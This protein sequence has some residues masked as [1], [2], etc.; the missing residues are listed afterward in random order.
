MSDSH[1]HHTV[2]NAIAAW[3]RKYREALGMQNELA[4]CTPEQ[5]ATIAHDMGLSPGELRMMVAKG[6]H[7]ADELPKLLR[8]LGVDPQRLASKDPAKM[9]D[10]QRICVTCAHKGRC[11][12]D[13][14]QGTIAGHYH[15]YCPNA[16][17]IEALFNDKDVAGPTAKA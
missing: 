6:P 1:D 9:R 15:D 5:V 16:V 7:A 14:A 12:H 8:A 3:V 10:L 17:S 4:N 2:L 11:Q 13:L